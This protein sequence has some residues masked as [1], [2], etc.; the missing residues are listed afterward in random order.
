MSTANCAENLRVILTLPF[1]PRRDLGPRV[2]GRAVR[3]QDR[4]EKKKKK[5]RRSAVANSRSTAR[6]NPL[7]LCVTC[8]KEEEV[9]N[10][11]FGVGPRSI[12]PVRERIFFCRRPEHEER[13][14]EGSSNV[15]SAYTAIGACAGW[16]HSLS[17]LIK[18]AH[19]QT[20]K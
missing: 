15:I 16:W 5:R 17:D 19:T 13:A 14:P 11:T 18:T 12:R 20:G 2:L 10:V 6:I 8:A 1:C 4:S 9:E 3:Q 7:E